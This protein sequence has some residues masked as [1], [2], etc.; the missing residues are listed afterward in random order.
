MNPYFTAPDTEKFRFYR[1]PK[2]L[3]TD[4]RYR[5]VSTDAKMLYGLLLD[6]LSL[7]EK[8]AGKTSVAGSTNISPSVRRR[9]YCTSATKRSA[10]CLQ[11]W[12]QPTSSSVAVRDRAGPTA[13][14]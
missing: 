3:F 8:T 6:R 4:E 10:V 14:T 9:S 11:S 7:S 2:L 1:I 13:S 12:K 5:P